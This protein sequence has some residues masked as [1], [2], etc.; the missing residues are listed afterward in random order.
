MSESSGSADR[1][2]PDRKVFDEAAPLL[3]EG[4]RLFGDGRFREAADVFYRAVA[5]NPHD[6]EAW[7]QLG[8]ALGRSGVYEDALAASHRALELHPEAA[9]AWMQLGWILSEV[10]RSAEALDALDHALA[11]DPN[12]LNA[13]V[14][15]G[16]VPVRAAPSDPRARGSGA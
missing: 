1:P 7:Q 15:K 5:V 16:Q 14:L 9:S 3:D 2:G 11:L 10:G 12:N 8:E 6:A 4:R 13:I